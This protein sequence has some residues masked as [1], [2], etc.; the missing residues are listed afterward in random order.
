M[1]SPEQSDKEIIQ[2][3]METLRALPNP[4]AKFINRESFSK[5]IDPRIYYEMTLRISRDKALRLVVEVKRGIAYPAD[6]NG[7]LWRCMDHKRRWSVQDGTEET[8]FLLIAG[9]ISPGAK[10]LLQKE[11]VGYFDSGGSLYL[12]ATDF[13]LYVEKPRPKA[14]ERQMRSLFS[15]RRGQVLHVLLLPQTKG[16]WFGVKEL[17]ALAYASSATVSEVLAELEHMEWAASRGRGPTKERLLVER[18]A[19]LDAWGLHLAAARPTPQRRYYVPLSG[20]ETL[21]KRV[22]GVFKR[23][24][25]EYAVSYEAAAQLYAPFLTNISQV[26]CRV[27]AGPYAEAPLMELGAKA[28]VEGANLML[29][30]AGGHDELLVGREEHDGVCLA[31]PVQ[32]YLDL[33]RG[34]GRAKELA[35]HLRREKLITP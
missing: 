17:A 33:L 14:L 30:D 25:V 8:V 35:E 19:L 22:S 21:L 12:P 1:W 34:E 32:V 13:H 15:E 3:F 28:V 4:N 31:S 2:E 20:N 27:M 11:G 6:V 23:L 18:A 10:D 7:L 9:A 24:G 5:S 16:R 29:L 26:R